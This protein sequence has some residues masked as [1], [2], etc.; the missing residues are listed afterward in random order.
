LREQFDEQQGFWK[1]V[2][3]KAMQLYRKPC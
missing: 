1:A 2:E 3:R